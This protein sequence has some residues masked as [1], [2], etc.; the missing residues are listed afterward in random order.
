MR[1]KIE[2]RDKIKAIDGMLGIILIMVIQLLVYLAEDLIKSEI[3]KRFLLS[4]SLLGF[5]LPVSFLGIFMVFK[6]KN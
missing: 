3:L 6:N 2:I 4:F 1:E 5:I